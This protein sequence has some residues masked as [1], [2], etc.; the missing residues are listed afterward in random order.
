MQEK[1]T[2]PTAPLAHIMVVDD[3]PP[4]RHLV[5][6]WLKDA[7]YQ[8]T[9]AGDGEEAL[10]KLE[11]QSVDLIL[12]DLQM[13]PLGGFN[14][15]ESVRGTTLNNIPTILITA[16][17]SSDI[18]MRSARM[19]FNGVMKKPIERTRLL[20]MIDQQLERRTIPA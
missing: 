10:A 2:S 1:K 13:E 20:Q 7:G 3:N 15:K 6:A 9:E 4:F 12:L 17:P 16:D 8:I 11:E 14:F 19:G 5:T 18:L